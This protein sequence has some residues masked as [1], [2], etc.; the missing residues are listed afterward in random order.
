[1]RG[2]KPKPT[3]LRVLQGNAGHRP[4][5]ENEP[6]PHGKA[7][8]PEWMADFPKVSRVWDEV[9]PRIEAMGLLTDADSDAFARYCALTSEFRTDPDA[10]TAPKHARLDVLEAKFGMT[11]SDR[12]RMGTKKGKPKNA[13]A[14][15]A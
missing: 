6:Q 14:E 7:V 15:I 4:L 13:F 11:P 12:A 3:K 10:F 8:K 2:R 9:A 1:M 5:P